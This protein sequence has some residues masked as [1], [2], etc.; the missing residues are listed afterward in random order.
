MLT[1]DQTAELNLIPS[2]TSS[3]SQYGK[4]K[5]QHLC[6]GAGADAE[7]PGGTSRVV[8]VSHQRP[9]KSETPKESAQVGTSSNDDGG[10]LWP[11]KWSASAVTSV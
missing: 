7:E 2:T 4:I 11:Q 6:D 9:S 10:E 1:C 3:Y 8:E 5:A